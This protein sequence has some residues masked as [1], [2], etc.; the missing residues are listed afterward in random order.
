MKRERRRKKAQGT[1]ELFYYKC[2]VLDKVWEKGQKKKNPK[3]FQYVFHSN[4][5]RAILKKMLMYVSIKKMN[6]CIDMGSQASH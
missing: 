1:M 5:G 2:S 4:I 3:I 6:K